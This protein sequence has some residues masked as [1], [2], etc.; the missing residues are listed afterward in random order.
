M[1][2][3]GHAQTALLAP[4]RCWL[5]ALTAISIAEWTYGKEST[6]LQPASESSNLAEVA[7]ARLRRQP[8]ELAG[9]LLQAEHSCLALDRVPTVPLVGPI[10][11]IDLGNRSFHRG[12]QWLKLLS[13]LAQSLG[14]VC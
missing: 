1:V 10:V 5:A 13:E 3:C 2:E 6:L 11:A 7:T 4:V 8:R 12:A 14:H 9:H